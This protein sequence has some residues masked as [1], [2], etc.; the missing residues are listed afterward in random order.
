MLYICAAM[1]EHHAVTSWEWCALA[2]ST[3]SVSKFVLHRAGL[4]A[5]VAAGST[6]SSLKS[7]QPSA[8]CNHDESK[9]AEMP[10]SHNNKPHDAD[11]NFPHDSCACTALNAISKAVSQG[12]SG[13]FGIVDHWIKSPIKFTKM[14]HLR[15]NPHKLDKCS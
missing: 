7:L 12:A 8:T 15:R 9:R 13:S 14:E 3:W 1:A 6:C 10:R 11:V 2:Y 5:D 4:S